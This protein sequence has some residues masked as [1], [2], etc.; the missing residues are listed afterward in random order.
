ML[1][2]GIR[3]IMKENEKYTDMLEY[4]DKTRVLPIKKIRR[5]FTIKQM[6]YRKLKEL[7]NRTGKSMSKLLDKMIDRQE[8]SN[9]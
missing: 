5:S 7:S 8:F 3:K 1:S 4:Y 9:A 2:Q 6:N